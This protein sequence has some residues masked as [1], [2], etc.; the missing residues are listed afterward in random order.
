MG[1]LT[2]HVLDAAHGC[3][4][5]NIE[6]ELYRV[7]GTH[8][9]LI[10]RVRT[11]H[12]GR[13]DAPVLQGD[14]YRSGTYQLHFHAGDYYRARGV[15]LPE[16]AFL[17]VVV[18]RFGIDGAKFGLP[19]PAPKAKQ[20]VTSMLSAIGA[21]HLASK[22]VGQL[23]GGEFQRL[24]VGQALIN[25][26]KLI[27]A[28]E[29]LSALDLH[30]Q[31]AITD[32]IDQQRRVNNSSVLF[33]THD[34]NPILNQ[35]NRVLYLANGRFK[36]G[37]PDEVLRSEVLSDLYETPVD[38]LRNQGRIVVVGNSHDHDHFDGEVWSR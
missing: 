36:I 18:L 11:N 25:Q 12:D 16:Q 5:S 34:V 6:V 1:R 37:T 35:V 2:T 26:P 14:D 28:D 24:R 38:V 3:P 7:D 30:Q 21:E 22:P 9:E 10:T 8:L 4:G 20:R 17:D 23:S 32:L 19:L 27:L 15:K 29:P 13:C 33:V 31:G